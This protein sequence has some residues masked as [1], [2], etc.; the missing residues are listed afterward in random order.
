MHYNNSKNTLLLNFESNAG[1]G[2][3]K[4]LSV[5]SNIRYNVP[6]LCKTLEKSQ[7]YFN[8]NSRQCS[9]V[10]HQASVM[11]LTFAEGTTLLVNE[12]SLQLAKDMCNLIFLH[13]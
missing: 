11:Q 4:K 1:N 12:C 5:L 3:K 2:N 9:I 7:F 10:I 6:K 8:V 13:Y